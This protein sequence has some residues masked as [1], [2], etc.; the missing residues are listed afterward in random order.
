[1]QGVDGDRSEDEDVGLAGRILTLDKS[2]RAR[3]LR[4]RFYLAAHPPALL[5]LSRHCVKHYNPDSV[6]G[7][8]RRVGSDRKESMHRPIQ[9]KV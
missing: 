1:M 7:S 5:C 3:L 2:H 4:S 8:Q 6:T 9:P